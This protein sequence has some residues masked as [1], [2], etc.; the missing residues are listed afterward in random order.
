MGLPRPPMQKFGR[1]HPKTVYLKVS[2]A[3]HQL[4]RYEHEKKPLESQQFYRTLGY[5]T[6]P[7]IRLWCVNGC[8]RLFLLKWCVAGVKTK[9]FYK[10]INSL[11]SENVPNYGGK[12]SSKIL[13]ESPTHISEVSRTRKSS[14]RKHNP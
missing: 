6:Q 1:E 8:F 5:A 10:S 9:Y 7:P 2:H 4:T 11:R 3:E 13:A 14:L 12:G